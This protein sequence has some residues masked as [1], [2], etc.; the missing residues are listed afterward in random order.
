MSLWIWVVNLIQMYNKNKIMRIFAEIESII[1][2]INT[3]RKRMINIR[4][5]LRK[6]V[7]VT[8]W[9]KNQIL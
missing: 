6:N 3:N 9:K 2:P 4:F 8:K 5:F 7:P 1:P